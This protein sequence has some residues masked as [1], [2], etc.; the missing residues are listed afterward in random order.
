MTASLDGRAAGA[1]PDVDTAAELL[2][3]A[4][5]SLTDGSA[6]DDPVTQAALHLIACAAEM[7][8]LVGER[9][10]HRAREALGHARAAVTTATYAVLRSHDDD[11]IVRQ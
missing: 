5:R 9:D 8:T 1:S 6:P 11:R 2:R 7:V 3:T 4:H 10:P